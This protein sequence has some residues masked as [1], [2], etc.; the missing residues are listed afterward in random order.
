MY[1]SPMKRYA[2]PRGTLLF[3]LIAVPMMVFI[4]LVVFDGRTPFLF[5]DTP[6]QEPVTVEE[7]QISENEFVGP[8]LDT[9]EAVYLPQPEPMVN[10]GE[11]LPEKKAEIKEEKVARVESQKPAKPKPPV[12]RPKEPD[13]KAQ[14]PSGSP[15]KVVIIIDDMGMGASTKKVISLP[16]PL[17]LSYLPYA[18]NL[19]EQTSLARQSGHELMLHMPMEPSGGGENP[20]PGVLTTRM[21]E[22]ELKAALNKGLDS[23]SGYGG[24]N[25]HM[26]S[27]LTADP[28]AMGWVMDVLKQR[29]LF[30]I[31][32]K[33]VGSSAGAAMAAQAGIPFASRDVFLDHYEDI[34]S[35]R[36]SLA[37][38][39]GVARA[40]GVAIAIGHPHQATLQALREWL[41]TLAAKNITLVKASSVVAQGAAQ[42][43]SAANEPIPEDHKHAY[44]DD[45]YYGNDESQELLE[46]PAFSMTVPDETLYQVPVELL[47]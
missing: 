10:T 34:N 43:V 14:V 26:G 30:F 15:G 2:N 17:T 13:W 40:Q 28:Q 12:A 19:P 16:G 11:P 35:V 44:T 23:F 38:L 20:G 31:D 42:A 24:I 6:E 36:A 27:K 18:S 46:T 37:K 8:L 39:E 9:P 32:S 22:A 7:A 4:D 41:P 45:E 25:N 47:E 21:G 33:T 3:I 5:M 1:S 29:G